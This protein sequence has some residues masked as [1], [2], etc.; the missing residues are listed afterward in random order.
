MNVL[1]HILTIIIGLLLICILQ[2][3]SLWLSLKRRKE[4]RAILEMRRLEDSHTPEERESMLQPETV[5][6]KNSFE[7]E[8]RSGSEEFRSS[9]AY[10]LLSK[11]KFMPENTLPESERRTI[12]VEVSNSFDGVIR[13]LYDAV[14]DIRRA[15]I[16]TCMLSFLDCDNDV[17]AAIECVSPAAIRQR[18]SRLSK[19][20]PPEMFDLI[21]HSDVKNCREG[22]DNS[23]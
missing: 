21:M 7:Q 16:N 18:K 10:E 5:V 1:S 2:V 4:E 14:P 11:L 15:D 12:V 9:Q 23:K 3:L 13:E 22:I 19:R 6:Q 20:M 17:I 8:L